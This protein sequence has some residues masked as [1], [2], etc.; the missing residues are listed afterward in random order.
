MLGA[1][2]ISM[3]GGPASGRYMRWNNESEN[4]WAAANAQ[5]NVTR[6]LREG[7][8][9]PSY[10]VFVEI[11]RAAPLGPFMA[12]LSKDPRYVTGLF[13][14]VFGAPNVVP[15]ELCERR[16]RTSEVPDTTGIGFGGGSQL[17]SLVP[18]G[19]GAAD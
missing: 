8:N 3:V 10:P 16:H 17:G 4:F 9:L 5:S 6:R 18:D 2:F 1:M 19:Y 15:C 14:Q 13:I 7:V 12:A 11:F